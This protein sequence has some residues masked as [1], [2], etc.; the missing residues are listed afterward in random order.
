MIPAKRDFEYNKREIDKYFEFLEK[1]EDSY[2]KLSNGSGTEYNVDTELIN[3]LK[4]NAYLL[5]YNLVESTVRNAIWDIFQSIKNRNISYSE[6]ID[7]VKQSIIDRKVK[8]DFKTKEETISKQ[9]FDII[10]SVIED[11]LQLLPTS[12]EKII[13]EAGNLDFVTIQKTL[14]KYGIYEGL[15][16]EHSEQPV[17]FKITKRN[18]NLLAHGEKTFKEC[19]RDLS[20][21]ELNKQKNHIIQFLEGK[22]LVVVNEYINQKK[23]QIGQS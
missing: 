8:I 21:T 5:L 14:K 16:E 18:R 10:E 13:F 22:I 20:Y 15:N 12:K 9:V 19:G 11:P 6:F 3:I 2:V 7:E 1:I 4:A 23:Y 17:A